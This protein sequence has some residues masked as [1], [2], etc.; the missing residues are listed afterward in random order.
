MTTPS[1]L[2]RVQS[3]APIEA[4][5]S[6]GAPGPRDSLLARVQSRAPIEAE[7]AAACSVAAP[8]LRAYNRAP[9]LKL[10]DPRAVVGQR[11]R[12]R[13]YNRAPPLKLRR[14]ADGR[15]EA[16]RACARTIARPH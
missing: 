2:A 1:R 4:R 11:L 5:P 14:R 13:A 10:P 3:R 7:S 6:W 8:R 9:P 16:G 12:L 15:E